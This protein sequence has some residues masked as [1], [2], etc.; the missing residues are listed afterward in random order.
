MPFPRPSAVA[1]LFAHLEE[2][3]PAASARS[4]DAAGGGRRGAAARAG[5]GAGRAAGDAAARWSP[6][7]ARRSGST[8]PAARAAAGGSPPS[9]LAL[10][11]VARRSRGRRPDARRRRAAGGARRPHPHRPGDQRRHAQHAALAAPRRASWSP[12][13]ASGSA[14]SRARRC[15]AS[16]PPAATR[17]ACRTIGEPRDLAAL[18]N[19]VYVASDGAE[20]FAGT[21]TRYDART[22]VRGGGVDLLACAVGA[23][24]GVVWAA[25]CSVRR[26][27]VDRPGPLRVETQVDCR[28]PSRAPPPTTATLPRRRRRR[29]LGLAARRRRRP[30]RLPARPRT[31]A[32]SAHRPAARLRP[33]DRRRRG[34]RMGDGAAGRRRAAHRP[35]HRPQVTATIPVGR[36]RERHR[37]GRRRGVGDEQPRRHGVARST[38]ASGAGD[39]DRSTSVGARA[40]SRSARAAS[41]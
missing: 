21:V 40:R 3:P 9:S 11:A 23:G 35:G 7:R 27:P 26:P 8:A 14:T 38:R 37:D 24:E 31:G 25:G 39:G 15:T 28:T 6:R 32:V 20:V 33:L 1:T 18:G 13:T 10:A 34:R 12:A 5:Q 19:D 4:A 36:G 41:G 17:S 30:P 2:P 29:G 16:T 22:G